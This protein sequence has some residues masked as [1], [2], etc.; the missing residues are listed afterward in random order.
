MKNNKLERLIKEGKI[1]K[2]EEFVSTHEFSKLFG[3]SHTTVIK[4]CNNETIKCNRT[5]GKHRRIPISEVKRLKE[6]FSCK[7]EVVSKLVEKEPVPISKKSTKKKTKYP[8]NQYK[9]K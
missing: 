1:D 4:Y 3:I 5:I 6:E 9:K 2:P 7:N 8:I